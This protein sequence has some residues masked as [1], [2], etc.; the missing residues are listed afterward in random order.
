MNFKVGD[1][2]IVKEW[3]KSYAD[4]ESGDVGV[5]VSCGSEH[6]CN[7]SFDTVSIRTG[8]PR[9]NH[10]VNNRD[11]ELHPITKTKLWETLYES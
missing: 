10:L 3:I 8:R 4:Y 2:I 9:P 11:I 7:V 5:V 6:Y 1:L